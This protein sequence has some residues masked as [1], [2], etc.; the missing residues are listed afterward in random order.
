MF[1]RLIPLLSSIALIVTCPLLAEPATPL[2][3][4]ARMPVKEITVFKDGHAFLLHSG[5]MPTDAAGN[6]LLDALPQPVLGTFWP[7]SAD[8]SAKLTSVTASSHKVKLDRTALSIR[9]LIEANLGASVQITE[10]VAVAGKE[11][12]TIT[13]AGTLESVPTQ[14]GEELEATSVP[15]S[16]EK[17]PVRGEMVL[18]KTEA[19]TK[20]V[21]L[22]RI[23]D[24]TFAQK[25]ATRLA[26]EEFRNLLTLK[27]DWGGKPP[28]K[29]ADVGMLYLQKGIRWIPNYKVAIDGKGQAVV[30]L[31]ATLINELTDLEDVTT[32]L[33]IGVPTFAFA[34]T[35]D[36]IAL[37]QAAA[38]LSQYFAQPGSTGS[39]FD[40]GSSFAMSNSIMSQTARMGEVR[41]GQPAAAADLGP[42]IASQGKTED[43]YLFQ[44]KH[45]TLKKGQRMVLP[46][47]EYN[48]KYK[49][50]YTLDIPVTPPPEVLRGFDASRKGE[51][52]R[53]L[54][55]PKAMH[56][57]RLF[58]TSD[59]PL[60]TAP[61]LIVS[62]DRVIAQGM[63]NYTAIGANFDLELTTAIDVNVR[64]SD[65]ETARTPDA[66]KWNK[67]T[68]LRIDMAGKISLTNY[69]K[70][71]VELEVTRH[72]MGNLDTVDHDGKKESVNL[73]EDAAAAPTAGSS[74][75]QWYGWYAWPY[76]WNRF[77]G[78]GKATWSLTVEPGKTTD[79]AYTW[80]YFWR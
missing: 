40:N 76:W 63:M 77:N 66:E 60:T 4:L 75:P 34:N 17:L 50:V 70:Q 20:A 45:V 32:N 52:A 30:R 16:G 33:V 35:T 10:Q 62:N 57:I 36:P 41:Q 25:P 8:K 43:L 14:T 53:L 22:N 38:Q 42:E 54:A 12:Q 59:A 24:V 51:I 2:T 55:A 72:L 46:V 11:P 18:I 68:F 15:N 29:Q 13:Y 74:Y 69:G 65:Q 6:V 73:L 5:K 49:D 19:G 37:Q 79:L 7:Y 48:L 71:P 80:H 44:V 78:V 27:L 3:A 9:E 61:A 1:N 39:N 21:N 56:K 47:A 58:N 67:E 26:H 31:Q 64:K 23:L 28:E